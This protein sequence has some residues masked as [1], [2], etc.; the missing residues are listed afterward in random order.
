[1]TIL[2]CDLGTG[3]NKASLYANDGALLASVF[4]GYETFYPQSGFHE[5]RPADW[6]N[7]VVRSI[8]RL[9]EMPEVNPAEVSAIAL[10]GHSLGC[11]PFDAQGNLLL[12]SVPIWSDSRAE[13]QA[14]RFFDSNHYETWYRTTGAGFP[15]AHYTLF[16]LLWYRE[17]LPEMFAK[18]ARFAG[19]K[20]FINYRLTGRIATDFSYASGTGAYALEA[21]DYEDSIL[22]AAGLS[23]AIFPEIVPSSSVLGTLTPEAAQT[24]GLPQSVQVAAGGVDNSCMALG[25][26]AFKNGRSYASL[27]SSSWVAVSDEKPLLDT[28]FFPYVFAHVVPGQ[29]ASATAIF[30]A[31]T[32]LKWIRDLCCQDLIAECR[33]TGENVYAR[34]MEL[35]AQSPVGANGLIL[36]PT[37]AGGSCLEPSSQMRGGLLGLDLSHTRSDVIRATLEGIA[38][39]LRK[40]LDALGSLTRIEDPIVLVG[41]GAISPIWRQI[42]ADAFHRSVEKTN[43][44][45]DAAAL[46]AAALAAVGTGIWPNFDRIDAIHQTESILKPQTPDAYEAILPAFLKTA[47]MLTQLALMRAKP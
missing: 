14:R 30:S 6:W 15:P 24:L 47:E 42:Y 7:A 5:Q 34:M 13:L 4:E 1:M 22:A 44:D 37:F 20:D 26:R 46:G 35:A 16:K 12:E 40:A 38:L 3:G 25:A 43:I 9:L 10:S 8:R 27:G 18:M 45:Q 2:A 17:N 33:E 32:T 31:G 19:T 41:G 39:N 29:F 11:V 28:R 23:R 36:N 21:W